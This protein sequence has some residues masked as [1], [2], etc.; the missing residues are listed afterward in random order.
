MKLIFRFQSKS[1]TI[2]DE[3]GKFLS[4]LHAWLWTEIY[5][6][7]HQFNHIIQTETYQCYRTTFSDNEI[8]SHIV[9]CKQR[10]TQF[11]V[12]FVTH[13][14]IK[15][16]KPV[17]IR[18]VQGYLISSFVFCDIEMTLSYWFLGYHGLI[19]IYQK[20]FREQLFLQM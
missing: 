8:N 15:E 9:D 14:R 7:L 2:V 10:V 4:Q 6:Q 5:K 3:K 13:I 20:G 1:N 12:P 18:Q 19:P 11:V 17:V 16:T